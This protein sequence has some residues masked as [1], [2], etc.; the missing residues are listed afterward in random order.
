MKF[1]TVNVAIR[2]KLRKRCGNNNNNNNLADDCLAKAGRKT[3]LNT[4]LTIDIYEKYSEEKTK[5]YK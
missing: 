3:H 1:T 2:A 4:K 5:H